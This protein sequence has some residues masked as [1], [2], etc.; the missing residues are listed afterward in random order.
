MPV[1]SKHNTSKESKALKKTIKLRR[2]YNSNQN[3][4]KTNNTKTHNTKTH[5]TKTKHGKTEFIASHYKPIPNKTQ[6]KP[7]IW[8][9]PNRK[10]FYNW[11]IDTFKQY[12]SGNTSKHVAEKPR[13]TEQVELSNI[14][15]LTRDY[16]Q[17]EGPARGLLL[18]IGLGTGKTCAAIAIS[19]AILTKKEVIVLSKA[20]LESNFRKELRK[21]G[22]DYV[23]NINHWV[24]SDCST[25]AEKQLANELG[26]PNDSIIENG[27]VF[28][29]DFTNNSSNYYSMTSAERAKLDRQIEH[30][31]NN[32]FTFIH[33]DS[34]RKWSIL[35][36]GTFD[37][38]IVIVDEVHNIGNTMAS[39]ASESATKYY[40]LF[41][42]AKNPKYIFLSGTPIIN[43]IY[44]ISRIFNILRGYMPYL[45]IVFKNTYDTKIDYE[46]IKYMLKKNKHVDQIVINASQKQITVSKN[47]DDFITD[48]SGKGILYKPKE[49]INFV[50]FTTEITLLIQKMGYK[51]TVRAEMEKGTCFVNDKMEFEKE[52]YNADLNKL[53]N[54]DLIK[55][56]I[57]GL[58]SYYGYQDKSKYPEQLPINYVQVPMSD[59]QFGSYERY[60][61]DE[62]QKEKFIKQKKD[63]DSQI[64]QSD[65]RI[66]SRLACS[67]VFPEETGSPYDSKS[68]DEN[69]KLYEKLGELLDNNEITTVDLEIMETKIGENM[70][71]GSDG[72]GS[73]GSGSDGSGSDGS[74]SD[75]SGSDDDEDKAEI[76]KKDKK[77][78]KKDIW[79][80][81]IEL[82]FRD[83]D[84]YLDIKNGSL[85]RYSPKYVSMIAN[86]Q[87]ERGKQLVYSYFLN[88][89]G[90]CIFSYALI[91]TGKWAPFRL[92]K[93]SSTGGKATKKDTVWEIDE[94]EDEKGK[95]KFVFYTGSVKDK[96]EREISRLIYNS[97]WENL[98]TNTCGKLIQQL[99][100]IHSN[101]HYGEVIK[102]LMTTKTGAEGLDLKEVR[103]IH[104]ME[105]FWQP[106][107]IDQI[108]G[109]GV[110]NESHLKLKQEDRTVEVYIYM[111]SIT[112]NQIR[113]INYVAVR[114]DIYKYPNPALA[115][116]EN[117]VISSDE[118]LFLTAERKRI[119]V[120]EFQKL[121][122]E[123]AFDCVLN[124]RD[125]MRNPTNKGLICMDYPSKNRDE[126]LFTPLHKD[127]ADVVQLSQEKVITVQYGKKTINDKVYYF[128]MTPDSHGKMYIYDETLASRVRLPKPVGEVKII[129]GKRQ[130][131]FYKKKKK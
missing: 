67:F 93:T 84:K 30:I 9:L 25:E 42:D 102:M 56:R 2:K 127:T 125:N 89:I 37:N 76:A 50:D 86:I 43:Q 111:A 22:G 64:Q 29:V 90:L 51:I 87:K 128:D 63:E 119:I 97:T 49:A 3:K 83:K 66:K 79:S 69:I 126:Y 98:P 121:M 16:L 44:E 75:G 32:R 24:F 28:F 105:S 80:G 11:V 114:R 81:Y 23:K 5:N 38:K 58:T 130:F 52:F 26:I 100:A 45:E 1:I 12:E 109:R 112:P 91:Q 10:N 118:Y 72:S 14:Q 39:K 92:K 123:S 35:K 104:I 7:K 61:H 46:N 55:R 54:T 48:A 21:C 116:K 8:E 78:L 95:N 74:G 65:Y 82:L 124:Y 6:V 31:I 85:A 19:E 101:N 36:P 120:N 13:I 113:K 73:D 71:L 33:F 107:L 129:G 4:N 70:G 34:Y 15:R 47:P 62:I 88:L 40:E 17:G 117:K 18:Y 27:G 41:M 20:N 103:Y 68:F 131:G 57:A 99:K 110:R 77:Q 122:K 60:R 106:V 96:N 59:F 108:I 94:R 53:K 115:N